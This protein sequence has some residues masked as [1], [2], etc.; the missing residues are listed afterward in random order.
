MYKK[1]TTIFEDLRLSISKLNEMKEDDLKIINQGI[2]KLRKLLKDNGLDNIN[3]NE[4]DDKVII[5]TRYKK[6]TILY[7]ELEKDLKF[8]S[9]NCNIQEDNQLSNAIMGS[10]LCEIYKNFCPYSLSGNSPHKVTAYLKEQ[11]IPWKPLP[12]TIISI[13]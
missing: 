7:K 6:F 3:I 11:K 13:Q 10:I 12:S 5:G 8:F 1:E 2:L 9:G 4:F